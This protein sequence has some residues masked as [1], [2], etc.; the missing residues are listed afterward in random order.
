MQIK[1][2]IITPLD[3]S[4]TK[5]VDAYYPSVERAQLLMTNRIESGLANIKYNKSEKQK[6]Q[7]F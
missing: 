2:L 6:F 5:L 7:S 3:S 4:R 1:R